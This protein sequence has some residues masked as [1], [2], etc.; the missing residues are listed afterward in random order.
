MVTFLVSYCFFPFSDPLPVTLMILSHE[1]YYTLM[2]RDDGY[3]VIDSKLFLWENIMK[4]LSL[5]VSLTTSNDVS[6][7]KV[8]FPPDAVG[9]EE[10]TRRQAHQAKHSEST[11]LCSLCQVGF[12][13]SMLQRVTSEGERSGGIRFEDFTKHIKSRE[14]AINVSI[15]PS[16]SELIICF[17]TIK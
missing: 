14:H 15:F 7:L 11:W 3:F 8:F 16:V 2:A 9:S 5:S 1:S 13:P 4:C 6:E 12:L 17:Y 10:E